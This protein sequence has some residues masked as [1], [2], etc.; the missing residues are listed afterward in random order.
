MENTAMDLLTRVQTLES[1]LAEKEQGLHTDEGRL[2]TLRESLKKLC[3]TDDEQKA[4]Q[5]V[6]EFKKQKEEKETELETIL[7]SVERLMA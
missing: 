6:V 5:K 3:G 2:S 7:D 1:D 4:Q